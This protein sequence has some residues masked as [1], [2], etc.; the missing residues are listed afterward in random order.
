MAL[1]KQFI[2]QLA[3]EV[4]ITEPLAPNEDQSYSFLLDPNLKVDIKE[5]SQ[6][7]MIS[8]FTRITKCPTNKI[9]DYFLKV[10]Q[11]NLLGHETGGGVIGLDKDGQMMTF[12]YLFLG[13]LIYKEFRNALEDFTNYADA[14]REETV[15]FEIEAKD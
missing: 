7:G 14:W 2:D 10:M 8:F 3:S 15:N 5:N 13:P 6:S 12:T 9:E 4:G 1:L 11:A